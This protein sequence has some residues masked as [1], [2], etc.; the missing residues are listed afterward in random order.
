MD[1][2]LTKR[3]IRL[4]VVDRRFAWRRCRRVLDDAARGRSF[5]VNV[6][7]GD[8]R[9][10]R[11][12]KHGD[13]HD[14]APRRA[15]TPQ[16]KQFRRCSSHRACNRLNPPSLCRIGYPSA[17]GRSVEYP[18]GIVD[19]A[20]GQYVCGSTHTKTIEDVWSIFKRDVVVT[21]HK[22]SAKYL[23]LYVA[24]FQFRYNNRA[25]PDIFGEAI[26]GA[27]D[28]KATPVHFFHSG[29]GCLFVRLGRNMFTLL[30][31]LQSLRQRL[32]RQVRS[33]ELQ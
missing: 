21:F 8:K 33:A 14:E 16:S 30:P 13:E 15:R 23:P 11:E 31:R 20:R 24:E 32:Q 17:T 18:H 6:S 2:G 12:R 5:G 22:V 7:L 19:H 27:N 26:R 25:N 4:A 10:K 9:L 28:D 29:D 1:D 3:A